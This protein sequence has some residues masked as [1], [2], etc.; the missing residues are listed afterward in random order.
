MNTSEEHTAGAD[1]KKR[2]ASNA[3]PGIVLPDPVPT[4]QKKA[5]RAIFLLYA[6][7]FLI[8]LAGLVLGVLPGTGGALFGGIPLWFSLGAVLSYPVTC[9][10][11]YF[12]VRRHFS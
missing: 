3:A 11:L 6:V 5:E 1:S 9:V 12:L 7:F 10:L 8:W 4:A 2:L